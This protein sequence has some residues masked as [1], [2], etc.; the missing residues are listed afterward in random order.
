MPR[1]RKVSPEQIVVT[2]R[3]I[4]VLVAQG[5]SLA[6]ACKE[7]GIAEQS[8]DRGLAR[9]LQPGSTALVLGLSAT[10]ARDARLRQPPTIA[11]H[12]AVVSH[13]SVQNPGQVNGHASLT[14]RASQFANS[15]VAIMV[16]R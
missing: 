3:Q 13:N 11:T 12:H 9:S 15:P 6:L 8:R 7:A 4:E 2:L 1:G 16:R 14:R 10:R 5:K